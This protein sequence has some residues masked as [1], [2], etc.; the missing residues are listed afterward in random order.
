MG[1]D[2]DLTDD[3]IEQLQKILE[4]NRECGANQHTMNED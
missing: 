2:L 3:D 1:D 4:A